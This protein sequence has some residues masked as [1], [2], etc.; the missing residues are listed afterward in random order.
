MDQGSN[1]GRGILPA[2]PTAS[3]RIYAGWEVPVEPD[4]NSGDV[5]AFER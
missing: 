4:F 1:N 2:P 3:S 5:S